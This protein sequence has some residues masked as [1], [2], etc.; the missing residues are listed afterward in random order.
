MVVHEV[1]TPETPHSMRLFGTKVNDALESLGETSGIKF[2]DRHERESPSKRSNSP[3][4]EIKRQ[5]TYLFFQDRALL[6]RRLDEFLELLPV[7]KSPDEKLNHLLEKLTI[8]YQSTKQR[9]VPQWQ[10]QFSEPQCRPQ[11]SEPHR[12][13][14]ASEPPRKSQPSEWWLGR[15]QPT[16]SEISHTALSAPPSPTMFIKHAPKSQAGPAPPI[17]TR[18]GEVSAETSFWSKPSQEQDDPA[19]PATSVDSVLDLEMDEVND[20]DT[21]KTDLPMSSI[22]ESTVGTVDRMLEPF[23][24]V[25]GRQHEA[26]ESE[27]RNQYTARPLGTPSK[28]PKIYN[29]SKSQQVDGMGKIQQLDT[30]SRSR[31]TSSPINR[32]QVDTPSKARHLDSPSKA[33]QSNAPSKAGQMDSLGHPRHLESPSKIVDPLV[34]YRVAR[35]VEDG[36]TSIS[37]PDSLKKLPLDLAV[38]CH[39]VLQTEAISAH[40]LDKK[41]RGSR[42]M[43][44]LHKFAE[45]YGITFQCGCETNFSDRSLTVV[46]QPSDKKDG[47]F[48]ISDV[49]PPRKDDK[50][51]IFE[52]KFGRDRI[53]QVT[54]TTY[55]R[56]PSGFNG[57]DVQTPFLE[58]LGRKH[59]MFGRTWALFLVQDKKMRSAELGSMKSD[60]YHIFYF[61][62]SGV[63]IQP[64]SISE[65]LDWALDFRTNADEKSCKLFARLDLFMSRT[66]RGPTL[67]E[68]QVEFDVEDEV[69]TIVPG[70]PRFVD[71][72][73]GNPCKS[74]DKPK[75]MT[76]GNSI[77]SAY[78]FDRLRKD[79]LVDYVPSV[80]QIRLGGNKGTLQRDQCDRFLDGVPPEVLMQVR[81]SMNKVKR[82]RRYD[83]ELYTLRINAFSGP[84]RP[85]HIYP[86]SL[87]IF[88]DRGVPKQVFYYLATQQVEQEVQE[89][90]SVVQN[91]AK[92]RQWMHSQQNLSERAT[93][94][95]GIGV[96]AGLPRQ[97]TEKII[98]LLEAGFE[99]TQC[100]FL[101]DEILAQLNRQLDAKGKNFKMALPRST[102]LIGIPDP[103]GILKPDEVH[104][105]F[106]EPFPDPS[107]QTFSSWDGLDIIL[108]RNP[109]LSSS[110]IQKATCVRN[111]E[112]DRIGLHDVFV[113]SIQGQQPLADK[114]SG[115][116]YDGDTFW[117]S[118]EPKITEKFENAPA[119]MK[120]PSP[121]SFGIGVDSTKTSDDIT[122][123]ASALQ[124][125]DDNEVSKWALNKSAFRMAPS[126]LGIVTRE[127]EALVYTENDI[128]SAKAN[129]LVHLHDLLVDADKNGYRY[130]AADWKKTKQDLGIPR[131]L[132]KPAHRHF[133]SINEDKENEQKPDINEDNVVDYIYYKIVEPNN[134]RAY[135]SA[136]KQLSEA[137]VLDPDL[138]KFYEDIFN[139]GPPDSTIRSELSEIRDAFKSLKEVWDL[140]Y[141]KYKNKQWSWDAFVMDCRKRYLAI[142]PKNMAHP[143]VKEWIRRQGATPTV[144]EKL[145]ASGMAKCMRWEGDSRM[146]FNVA[147]DHLI[148]LKATQQPGFRI[149][150][151][152]LHRIMRPYKFKA[153]GESV[154]GGENGDGDGDDDDVYEID[155]ARFDAAVAASPERGGSGGKRRRANSD[156]GKRLRPKLHGGMIF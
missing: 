73:L 47:R 100:R 6:D 65:F 2:P 127:H 134:Q 97:Q 151:E 22:G 142:Q 69:A 140:G 20:H 146:L 79:G 5:F 141:I 104:L 80:V 21:Q 23:D 59:E 107:G 121:E 89:F 9:Q 91:G 118:V 137:K 25:A 130:A 17:M 66:Q 108:Q 129:S 86:G 84:A 15:S 46:L 82:E 52:D 153:L 37:L 148:F 120:T 143:S 71:P 128:N 36:L 76:E 125:L 48:F 112:L 138:N 19:T 33:R 139:S 70:D 28:A 51:T 68:D 93:R 135:D 42:T 106:R 88:V 26:V 10:P 75:I 31:Q 85:S 77:A 122:I 38:E 114:L 95:L 54:T 1:E 13:P 81:K 40:E 16:L 30:P 63:G 49:K 154:D 155:R 32:R 123:P 53:M 60:I 34:N 90:R 57:Q 55:H 101:A 99:A 132:R 67:R 72:D 18:S 27:A 35:I 39:R 50:S 136:K 7:F 83:P 119:P 41:W 149:Q 116:D 147:G 45:D 131:N 92:F 133:T 110:D 96:L 111:A 152:N 105:C 126:M 8:A 74:L 144:W 12:Q 24:G 29:P 94:E 43:A 64:I 113:F 117:G 150:T 3:A 56:P 58:M 62:V 109:A 11:P 98:A 115:G 44:S 14:Q 156:A 4:H 102:V 145:K 103:I 78:L 61:A 87:P 124:P